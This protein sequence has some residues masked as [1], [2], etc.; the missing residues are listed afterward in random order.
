MTYSHLYL[1]PCRFGPG[2]HYVEFKIVLNGKKMFFTVETAPNKLMP[3][4][5]YTFL[6]MVDQKVWDN[7]VFIH[8]WNHIIQASPMSPD[9]LEKRD[10]IA[11][12]L[13]FP[14]YSDEYKHEKDTLGFSGRPGG[15]EFYINLIDNSNSHGPGKQD[16]STELNDADPCFAKLVIGKNALELMRKASADAMNKKDVSFTTI[17]SVHIVH[18]RPDLLE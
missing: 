4:S 16:H 17:E 15:P 11:Y 10:L 1:I 6:M 8:H 7:T 14:E 3:H 18:P 9:G 5:V 13:G 2:P 12:E